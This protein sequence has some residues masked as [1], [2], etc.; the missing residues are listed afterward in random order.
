MFSPSAFWQKMAKVSLDIFKGLRPTAGQGRSGGWGVE[1]LVVV[2]GWCCRCG[3][4]FGEVLVG[5]VVVIGVADVVVVVVVVG[6]N[7]DWGPENK[8]SEPILEFAWC[9][10]GA[11]ME[12]STVLKNNF[13]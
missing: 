4:R 8:L 6:T 10:L 13:G 3:W 12:F 2:V 11:S 7:K 5:V 9:S 1:A